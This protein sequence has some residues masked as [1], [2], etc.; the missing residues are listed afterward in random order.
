LVRAP[1]P[2]P[3]E[4]RAVLLIPDI[5][6][7][8]AQARQIL[9]GQVRREDAVYNMGRVALLVNA[10]ATGRVEDLR[11]ATQ[12]RLHQPARMA[13]LP[14]M[15]LLFESALNA[16]ALGVFLSGAGSTILALTRGEEATVAN[17]M[18]DA[19]SK[20]GLRAEAKITRPSP[21]GAQVVSVE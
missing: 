13:L 4:L 12:D 17:A 21:Q 11:V 20:A 6:M 16:G 10:L 15:R 19:A 2:V 18:A 5:P 9:P 7:P 3:S 14:P 1:V 8:T